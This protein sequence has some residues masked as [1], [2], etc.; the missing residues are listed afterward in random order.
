MKSRRLLRQLACTGLIGTWSSLAWAQTAPTA[1]AGASA[2][3]APALVPPKLRKDA[4]PEY[5]ATAL[6]QGLSAS[7]LLEID[8]DTAG[9]VQRASV[10]EASQA[11]D[12][13]FEEAALAAAKRLEFEPAL[14][15]GKPIAVTITFRF[16]FVPEVAAPPAPTPPAPATTPDAG[17]APTTK[18][19]PAAPPGE[20]WGR[21]LERGT[22]LPLVS[23]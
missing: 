7:V 23:V 5:P 19:A 13:G 21:L 11:P 18:P 3:P 17:K 1:A 6:E 15:A 22:R 8:I 12:Q 9:L 14:E 16:R 2:A 4:Q 10:A 20:L